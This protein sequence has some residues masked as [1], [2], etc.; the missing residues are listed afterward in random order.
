MIDTEYSG[1]LAFR[2]EFIK[3]LDPRLYTE[4]WL[5]AQ[6]WA[7]FIR[8][9]ADDDAALLYKFKSYPTG[10]TEL[11]YM[12]AAGNLETLIGTLRPRVEAH[13]KE[14]GCVFVSVASRAGWARKLKPHGYEQYQLLLR[15]EI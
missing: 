11:H 1:Y 14:R 12:A 6:V 7:G 3:I 2:D 4:E 9:E 15:K 8:A 5:D 10:A 13:A